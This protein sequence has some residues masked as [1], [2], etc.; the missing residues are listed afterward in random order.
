VSGQ[1]VVAELERLLR[2]N[3]E[4]ERALVGQL[5]RLVEASESSNADDEHDPEGSTV[6]FERQQAAALLAQLRRT[7]EELREALEGARQGR[8]GTCERC[9]GPIGA[10]RLAARPQARNCIACARLRERGPR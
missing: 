6:A 5:T 8:Y 1:D 2:T 3:G 7:G 10:E 4:Q 9:G